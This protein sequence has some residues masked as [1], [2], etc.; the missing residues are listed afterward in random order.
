MSTLARTLVIVTL[1]LASLF[2]AAADPASQRE[3]GSRGLEISETVLLLGIP[4]PPGSYTLKWSPSSGGDSVKVEI[5][6]GRGTLAAA[7]GTWIA[8]DRPAR[9]ASIVYRRGAAGAKHLA[10]IR[11]AGKSDAIRIDADAPRAAGD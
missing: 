5:V 2:A 4:V 9:D 11:F 10:E 1:F 6:D 8:S 7:T 3:R